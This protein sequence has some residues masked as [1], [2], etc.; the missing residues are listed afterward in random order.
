MLRRDRVSVYG[1]NHVL[2][3]FVCVHLC[4]SVFVSVCVRQKEENK[5]RKGKPG[6]NSK[7]TRGYEATSINMYNHMVDTCV[8]NINSMPTAKVSPK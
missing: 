7:T 6:S 2:S 8:L 4:V 5:K 3:V 1:L